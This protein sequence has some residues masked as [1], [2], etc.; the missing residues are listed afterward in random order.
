MTA[1][2]RAS[3]T[4][5][6][7]A[8]HWQTVE[9]TGLITETE[10][11]KTLVLTR[12]DWPKYLPG[13]HVDVRLTAPD[14]YQAQRSYSI[15]SSPEDST[16]RLTVERIEEGEVS[17]YF[18]DEVAKGDKFELRG[19][20]GRYFV[21]TSKL[22]GPLFL[23]AG[24]SGIV[25]LMSMLR[26][27]EAQN[28]DIPARL[29][30]SSRTERDIIYRAELDTLAAKNDGLTLVHTLTRERPAGW[31][32]RLGRIDADMLMQPGFAPGNSP[33]IFICG[34]TGF[35]EAAAN[36]LLAMG[37]ARSAIKTERFGPTGR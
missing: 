27:R 7:P 9:V 3:Q 21:W 17:P 22:G 11:V 34:P 12:P 35:V 15:A 14:G 19:P 29:L 4:T 24:G 18:T 1:I 26:H 28:S 31:N 6:Q 20:I 33:R 37:H 25:P 5:A 8:L 2:D 23:I 10:R 16:L 32:G 36:A 13:Q 30:F